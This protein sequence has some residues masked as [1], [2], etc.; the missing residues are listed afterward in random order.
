MNSAIRK[1]YNMRL[2][3][4]RFIPIS[5]CEQFSRQE[6]AGGDLRRLA[7]AISWLY[8][9]NESGGAYRHRFHHGSDR[10]NDRLHHFQLLRRAVQKEHRYF[11]HRNTGKS[12][13]RIDEGMLC[14]AVEYSYV[15]TVVSCN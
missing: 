14:C 3:E 2:T 6:A 15:K 5:N 10:A 9:L 12:S 7:A 8:A 4:S 13:G 11:P 1:K